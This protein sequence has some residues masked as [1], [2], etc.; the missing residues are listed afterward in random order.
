MPK[1]D[2]TKMDLGDEMPISW[3]KGQEHFQRFTELIR[4]EL[5]DSDCLCLLAKTYL[6]T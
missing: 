2:N 4:I 6:F 1:T 5:E 3:K